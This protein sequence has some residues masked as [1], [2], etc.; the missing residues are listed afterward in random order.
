M[1]QVVSLA[2]NIGSDEP[3]QVFTDLIRSFVMGTC[4]SGIRFI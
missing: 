3:N 1:S 2:S 4:L